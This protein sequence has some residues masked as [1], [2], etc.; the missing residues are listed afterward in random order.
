MLVDRETFM[1]KAQGLVS[2]LE[3]DRDPSRF[4]QKVRKRRIRVSLSEEQDE[5][6]DRCL[7]DQT[8]SAPSLFAKMPEVR[9]IAVQNLP[10]TDRKNTTKITA[11]AQKL[12]GTHPPT[13]SAEQ[14][15]ILLS[16]RRRAANQSV[17]VDQ[18]KA[19]VCIRQ[20]ANIA[21]LTDELKFD[22][23]K[24]DPEQLLVDGPKSILRA[25]A[26]MLR[27]LVLKIK[28]L[29]KEDNP[30][31]KHV[32]FTDV[33]KQGYGAKLITSVL[34]ANG[35]VYRP[36]RPIGFIESRALALNPTELVDVT[37]QTTNNGVAMLSTSALF[38]QK[39]ADYRRNA[40][41]E[42]FN[43]RPENIHGAWVRILVL[44]SKYKEGIDTFDVSYFHLF[45]RQMSKAERTQAV[46]RA[47]RMCGQKALPFVP[48][49]GWKLRV[50]TY[51]A[52]HVRSRV[53]EASPGLYGNA[54]LVATYQ[55]WCSEVAIDRVLNARLNTYTVK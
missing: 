29:D 49:K 19:G 43:A 5:A 4:A 21:S 25:Q 35:F 28:A 14:K 6:I 12:Y 20:R 7:E 10:R 38:Q 8:S 17:L 51:E 22:N 27:A 26:P 30:K 39:I 13:A 42:V 16:A 23:S 41:Q 53:I 15:A 54:D 24:F 31:K 47:V 3:S 45:G 34:V 50:Y 36:F 48:G 55:K 33:G 18:V 11:L 44:D 2:Y 32:I 40:L 46:G 37:T 52:P 1:H 9:H